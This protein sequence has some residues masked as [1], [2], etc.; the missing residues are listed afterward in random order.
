MVERIPLTGEITAEN[1]QYLRTKA[2]RAGHALDVDALIQSL[3]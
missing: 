3:Q 2:T 1:E